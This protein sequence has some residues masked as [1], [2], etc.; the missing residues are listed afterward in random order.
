[1]GQFT[2]FVSGTP[3]YATPIMCLFGMSP[4]VTTLGE[5]KNSGRR[6][7]KNGGKDKDIFTVQLCMMKNGDKFIPFI[8]FKDE[9]KS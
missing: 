1:M 6:T 7:V 2:C 8:I 9:P 3:T 5:R 4:L